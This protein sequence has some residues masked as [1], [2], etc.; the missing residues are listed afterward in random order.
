MEDTTKQP[1]LNTGLIVPKEEIIENVEITYEDDCEDSKE[2]IVPKEELSNSSLHLEDEYDQTVMPI[3]TELTL[4]KE[5]SQIRSQQEML[6]QGESSGYV[7][8]KVEPVD[9]A[10]VPAPEASCSLLVARQFQP[11]RGKASKRH[12]SPPIHRCDL[13][14]YT[15]RRPYRLRV[16]M[17]A[18][19]GVRPFSCHLCK[20]KFRTATNLKL[21]MRIHTGDKPYS[22]DLCERRFSYKCNLKTHMR[23]HTGLLDARQFPPSGKPDTRQFPPPPPKRKKRQKNSI[24]LHSCGVCDYTCRRRSGLL[25]HLPVHSDARPFRCSTC[26]SRFKTMSTLKYHMKTHTGDK[27]YVCEHC[28][29]KFARRSHLTYHLNSHSGDKPYTC[30]LCPVSYKARVSLTAHMRLHAGEGLFTCDICH[31][32]YKRKDSIKAHMKL[33]AQHKPASYKP[34]G[35]NAKTL[36]CCAVCDVNFMEINH[37]SAHMRTH[38]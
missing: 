22:C 23:A 5:I 24:T 21:H 14:D 38:R 12:K 9:E 16:H 4:S 37:L 7:E 35:S 1:S 20:S 17:L 26:D 11:P 29:R 2:F 18:H 34:Q 3:K 8:I 28:P 32:E 27:P 6:E 10:S 19:S 15:N 31:K 13:C 36:F 25:A 33:H 30:N